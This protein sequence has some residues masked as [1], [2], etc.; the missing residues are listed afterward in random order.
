MDRKMEHSS[1]LL[2]ESTLKMKMALYT[3]L[4]EYHSFLKS[5]G[6]QEHLQGALALSFSR[7]LFA[8]R[9]IQQTHFQKGKMIRLL[10]R[11]LTQ[12]AAF[13]RLIEEDRKVEK[14]ISFTLREI[15]KYLSG[16]IPPPSPPWLLSHVRLKNYDYSPK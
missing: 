11:D 16:D 14:Q 10:A 6:R 1:I 13:R 3:F 7:L 8:L 12:G 4:R 2:M 15:Q 5:L 9:T